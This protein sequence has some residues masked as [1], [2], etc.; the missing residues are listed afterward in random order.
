MTNEM[1][2]EIWA[3]FDQDGNLCAY[4]LYENGS[5]KYTRSTPDTITLKREV[6]EKLIKTL[7]EYTE[8]VSS[9]NNPN[10]F[11]PEIKDEG[12]YA[13]EFISILTAALEE[14]K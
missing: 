3:E 8:V 14:K 11:S 9:V 13:R 2:D 7:G 12:I 6:V 5:V 1:P 4:D 10:N